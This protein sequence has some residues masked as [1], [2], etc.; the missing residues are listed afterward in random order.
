M[1]NNLNFYISIIIDFEEHSFK[2]MHCFLH[3]I[4]PNNTNTFPSDYAYI[5]FK[6]FFSFSSRT[7]KYLMY[8]TKEKNNLLKLYERSEALINLRIQHLHFFSKK[9]G[10]GIC[11]MTHYECFFKKYHIKT[12]SCKEHD[13]VMH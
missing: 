12:I 1:R 11:V 8:N 3:P 2:Q 9:K 7:K 10:G 6:C 5:N 4:R 13:I